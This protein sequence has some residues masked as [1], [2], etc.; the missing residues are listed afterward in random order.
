M[1]LHVL[2]SGQGTSR[3]L[4]AAFGPMA[5]AQLPKLL[6]AAACIVFDADGHGTETMAQ[7]VDFASHQAG[8]GA[9]SATALIGFSIGC[10]R[11]RG[12]RVAGASAGAYLL[13]DGT[14]ASWPPQPWQIQWIRDLA[15]QARA[16]K[17]LLVASHTYQTYTEKIAGQPFA[18][19]VTVLRQATGFALAQGGPPTAPQVT[20][21]PVTGPP[22][23]GLWV[24]SYAS[25]PIDA[26]AHTYQG[27]PALH[28]LAAAHL[29]PWLAT[30]G[31]T[32]PTPQSA[33][34]A[35]LVG[36]SLAAGLARPMR[37]RL[38]AAG[39]DLTSRAINGST[40]D[41]WAHGSALAES[42][43][44]AT[45]ALTLVSL[46]TNDL[47]TKPADYKRPL[48]A[49]IVARIRAAGSAVA[50]FLPPRM[51]F[52]DRGGL[53][54]LLAAE[55]A[56]L[57]VPAFP[58]DALELPRGPDGIHPTPAG[59]DLWAARIIEWLSAPPAMAPGS[60][61]VPASPAWPASAMPTPALPSAPSS[62]ASTSRTAN[63]LEPIAVLGVAALAARLIR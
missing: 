43:A 42:L 9:V 7:I 5:A 10:S 2:Q 46:G 4:V 33:R 32:S 48:V 57:A 19:T 27:G 24:Y 52:A 50:W 17:T 3:P 35:L 1:P 6:G 63:G 40:I 53:R 28:Q 49:A 41:Q 16:G 14:H 62:P 59:F 15:D 34:R 26:P 18:S 56:R 37:D 13:V 20:R 21:D 61:V 12:L 44:Q 30:M 22:S 39:G 29:A 47:A 36:D 31:A 45:P 38:R 60:P 51:P 54:A 11:V 58:S 8:F 55:L 25:A 23:S